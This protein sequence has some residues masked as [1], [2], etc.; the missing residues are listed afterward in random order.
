MEVSVGSLIIQ[1]Q[2]MRLER[3]RMT[4]VTIDPIAPPNNPS[5]V[6]LQG[7]PPHPWEVVLL[8]C[9]QQIQNIG[10]NTTI[11]L[12]GAEPIKTRKGVM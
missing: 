3:R 5:L 1:S 10:E 9:Y 11:H 8:L 4:K 12:E 7:R 6:K 2:F